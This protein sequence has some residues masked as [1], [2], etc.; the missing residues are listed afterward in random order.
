MKAYQY[1]LGIDLGTS[2]VKVVMIRSDGRVISRG[3]ADLPPPVVFGEHHEQDPELWWAATA[4][5]LTETLDELRRNHGDPAHVMAI[6]VDAT[7]GT[8]VPVDVELRPL[9]P[10]LMYNDGRAKSQAARLNDMGRETIAR[11]GYRFNSSFSLAKLLW[12]LENEPTVFERTAWVL[13]QADFITA[14]LIGTSPHQTK[15]FSDESNALKTGYDILE[16]RWPDYISRTGIEISKLPAVAAIGETIGRVGSQVAA[17]FGLSRNCRIVGGMTDGTAAC[18]A[19][20][21]KHIGDM[22]T[23]LGTT[24]VWKIISASLVC[25]PQGR[26]YCHRHPS[27][28]FLPGGAGNAGGEGIRSFLGY[29]SE[30]VGERLNLL[31]KVLSSSMF[32]GTITYPLPVPGERF[33]FV[34]PGFEPFTTAGNDPQT[35]YRSCLEGIAC[36]ERWGYEVAA[37]LGADCSGKIWTTGRGAYLDAWMQIRADILGRPVC[38]AAFPESAFG[39]ALVAAMG[40]WYDDSWEATVGQLISDTGCWEPRSTHRSAG[41]DHYA[42]FREI[43]EARQT[44]IR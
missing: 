42:C 39:S 4:K 34:D 22:N 2:G 26:L 21:A 16:H 8:V 35:R 28:N 9:R 40:T 18:A 30:E 14:R 15:I 6:A 7:S 3:R 24:L 32:S 29:P 23:T 5:A 12:L 17:D 1:V 19:S 31:T 36:I 27:G 20:G 11:L 38:R 10:G 13:H 33:P 43:C 44:Q 37:E 41:E 25:D